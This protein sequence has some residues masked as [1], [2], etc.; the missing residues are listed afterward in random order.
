MFIQW[1]RKD[2]FL[3]MIS[4]KVYNIKTAIMLIMVSLQKWL[5]HFYCRKTYWRGKLSMPWNYAFS[6]FMKTLYTNRHG[7]NP[8]HELDNGRRWNVCDFTGTTL[9]P[10]SSSNF[11]F[12]H[13]LRKENLSGQTVLFFSISLPLD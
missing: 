4:I 11:D 3:S 10:R 8:M 2:I 12:M 1:D 5:A 7:V 13:K 9:W 6:S